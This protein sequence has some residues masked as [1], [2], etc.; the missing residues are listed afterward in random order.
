VGYGFNPERSMQC[1][2]E[3]GQVHSWT[4]RCLVAQSLAH[5]KRQQ[6]ALQERLTK[7]TAE[8]S[9]LKAQ[10]DETR[11]SYQARAERILKQ[12]Q[13][14][15]LLTVTT[16]EDR[17]LTK[18]FEGRGRPGPNSLYALVEERHLDLEIQPNQTAIEEQRLLAGWRIY[19][20][21]LPATRLSLEQALAYYRDEWLVEHGFHRFKRGSLPAL[22]LF[23]RLDERIRGLMLLLMVALQAL[24]LLEFVS[25]RHLKANHETIAGLVPGNPKMKT[26]HPSAER[27]LT[28]FEGLHLFIEE[29]ETH[30]NARMI[31]LLTPLQKRLLTLLDIPETIYAL[32]FSLPVQKFLDP[33]FV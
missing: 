29:S 5:A 31:E 10:S 2:L 17:T 13:L 7:A 12:R 19:V 27:I 33:P 23:L 25:Q 20:I 26:D 30:L 6:T 9:R 28:Q 21:N 16:R 32:S 1:P 14:E 8:L 3:N 11:D 4:E 18:Q 24:T 22:P 15:G